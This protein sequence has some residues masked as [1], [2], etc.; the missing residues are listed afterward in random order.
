MASVDS[1]D[2]LFKEELKDVYD[3][4][5]QLTKTLPKMAKKASSE[6]LKEAIEE[7]LQQTEEQV[8]RLERVFDELDLPARAKRCKGLRGIIEEGDEMVGEADNEQTRD[9]SIIAAAQ[10]V[11]HYEIATYGS[12]R[13]WASILGYDSVASILEE[14][15]NEEKEADQRLTEIAE[16]FV[17][18]TAAGE[19]DEEEAGQRSSRGAALMRESRGSKNRS[20]RPVAADRTS[21]TRK[22]KRSR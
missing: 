8:Q 17:N 16:S 4:E 6:E 15:L 11:E 20:R 22:G 14:T 1:L 5:K 12:L 2:A 21:D 13:T 9:A 10:K 7:H 3:A 18:E 19:E